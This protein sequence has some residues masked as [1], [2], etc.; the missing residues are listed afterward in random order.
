MIGVDHPL[1]GS[2]DFCLSDVDRIVSSLDLCP[3]VKGIDHLVIGS[4]VLQVTLLLLM[5]LLIERSSVAV[6]DDEYGCH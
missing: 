3:K 4:C 5:I 1:I 2:S 6:D